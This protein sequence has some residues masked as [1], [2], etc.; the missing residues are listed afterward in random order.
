MTKSA[1][2]IR[3]PLIKTL[4]F[5][6][7]TS[8]VLVFVS[9]ELGSLR[10][11]STDKYAAVFTNATQL[12]KDDPVLVNG[13]RVGKVSDISVYQDTQAKVSF[14]VKETVELPA[15][16][17]AAVRYRNLTGDRYL[18]LV[19]TTADAGAAL[20]KAGTTIPVDRTRP[21]LDLDV[22]LGG[23]KPLFEGLDHEQIN[24]LSAELIGVLQGEGDTVESILSQTASFSSTLAKRDEVIGRTITNLNSVLANLDQ[25]SSELSETVIGLNKLTSGLAKD[26]KRLGSS[27]D[28][29]D[30]L[31]TSVN[32]LLGDVRG[33]LK[34]TVA[35]TGRLSTQV[36]SQTK[37]LDEVLGRL[38]GFFFRIGRLGSRGPGYNLFVCSLRVRLTG[39]DGKAVFTPWIGPDP[40]L[41]RCQRG[42]APGETEE[43]FQEYVA[44]QK[45]GD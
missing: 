14:E 8:L 43:Q 41:K 9:I 32:S 22:L 34:E 44:K 4:I 37:L 20:L 23:L 40:G 10:F 25:H 38:P 13:V 36:S 1:I 42:A 24:R 35:Q 33:P 45:A 17:E 28:Q 7:S 29:V 39:A 11:Y 15:A 2:S 6:I 16:T 5:A 27:F 19:P 12:A 26:R 31:T 18:E 3:G 30:Q 21:A